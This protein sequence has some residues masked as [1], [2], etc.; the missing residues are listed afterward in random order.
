MDYNTTSLSVYEE[1]VEKALRDE[2]ECKDIVEEM[3][4]N[5]TISHYL[6]EVEITEK[7]VESLQ[8]LYE[9]SLD[10][11]VTHKEVKL[12][13]DG[14]TNIVVNHLMEERGYDV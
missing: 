14:L 5:G 13:F 7:I 12:G 8:W 11:P 2:Q 6:Q 4:K 1:R 3:W 9:K 10:K